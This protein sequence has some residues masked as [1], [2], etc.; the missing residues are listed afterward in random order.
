MRKL[1]DRTSRLINL[2]SGSKNNRGQYSYHFKAYQE[3]LQTPRVIKPGRK[4]G[5]KV[6]CTTFNKKDN[7]CVENKYC[8]LKGLLFY[9]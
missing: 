7:K 1:N 4:V 3:L 8:E 6:G 2:T 5:Y 9:F